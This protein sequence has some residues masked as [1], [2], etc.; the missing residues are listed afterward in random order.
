[1]TLQVASENVRGSSSGAALTVSRSSKRDTE[2]PT[3]AAGVVYAAEDEEAF[4]RLADA[5]DSTLLQSKKFHDNFELLSPAEARKRQAVAE[6]QRSQNKSNKLTNS[7]L[8]AFKYDRRL[9]PPLPELVKPPGPPEEK[10]VNQALVE[11]NTSVNA[12]MT[13]KPKA[14]KDTIKE[15]AAER[16]T[17]IE[18]VRAQ[19]RER[20]AELLAAKIADGQRAAGMSVGGLREG[21]EEEDNAAGRASQWLV[22]LAMARFAANFFEETRL[23]HMGAEDRQAYVMQE[24]NEARINRLLRVCPA[25][26]PADGCAGMAL[27]QAQAG[28]EDSNVRRIVFAA[29]IFKL[30][31]E[32]I[33]TRKKARM[34]H[35]SLNG[36]KVA[37]RTLLEL[38]RFAAKMRR[39]QRWWRAQSLRLKQLV[40]EFSSRW[41]K[42]ERVQIM[43]KIRNED[44]KNG[45]RTEAP[46]PLEDRIQVRLIP[47]GRR[48]EFLTNEFRALRWKHL[49]AV[50]L[51]EDGLRR[52]RK[53]LAEWRSTREARKFINDNSTA[54]DVLMLPPIQPSWLPSEADV[55]N[56]I[57]RCRARPRGG[58]WTALPFDRQVSN[59]T[60]AS[61]R[62]GSLDSDIDELCEDE[63]EL[64][65]LA[66]QNALEEMEMRK[67]G[68]DPKQLPC[69]HG[70]RPSPESGS[71]G[72]LLYA[73][74]M[75]S[76][77]SGR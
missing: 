43:Q 33:K 72:P 14:R 23:R 11:F 64:E 65:E 49:P 2:Q 56:M 66:R 10:V 51:Y 35:A 31:L 46:P 37:G 28:P 15:R 17:K 52:W 34:V 22:A 61:T 69:F 24:A 1:M 59:A 16:N 12:L 73:S 55:E 75:P 7:Q 36:W 40:Q 76:A 4:Q 70:G 38:R 58:G 62:R 57:S 42:L 8:K 30:R 20:K 48:I 41:V 71:G 5:L 32:R 50:T 13:Y 27:L 26:V 19:R 77:R 44:Q 9:E 25:A 21:E 3:M 6:Q 53:H 29:T 47:E 18:T 63:A 68:L 74:P 39:V 54:R 60:D 45:Q 67:M